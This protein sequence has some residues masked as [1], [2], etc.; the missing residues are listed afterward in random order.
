MQSAINERLMEVFREL[1]KSGLITSKTAFMEA[2]GQVKQHFAGFE[3]GSRK[4]HP[5]HIDLLVTKFGVNADYLVSGRLPVFNEPPVKPGNYIS[6]N[7]NVQGS[8]NV[9]YSGNAGDCEHQLALARL[10]IE[11]LK[12]ELASKDKYIALLEKSQG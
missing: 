5:K 11:G 1:K 12:R 7:A 2:I 9:K 10:E 8:S 3:D 6:G 4:V